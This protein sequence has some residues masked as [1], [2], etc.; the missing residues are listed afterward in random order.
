LLFGYFLP[1]LKF[2]IDGK[3]EFLVKYIVPLDASLLSCL[4]LAFPDSSITTLRSWVKHRRIFVN[5]KMAHQVGD[6]IVKGAT[7]E[8]SP[9]PLEKEGPLKIVYED[10]DLIVVDKPAGLL[11][12]ADEK[13]T[14]PSV[15]AWIKHRYP[16]KMIPV[17]HRLDKDT[18]GLI[19]FPLNSESF[20]KLKAMLAKREIK[21]VYRALLEGE[22]SGEGVWENFLLE[23]KRFVVRVCESSLK[24]S[25]FAKTRYVVLQTGEKYSLLDC[26]LDTGKKNQIRVQAAHHGHPVAGDEKYG[27]T[28]EDARRLCLHARLLEF[29]HPVTKKKMIFESNPPHFFEKL[30]R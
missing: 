19:L 6:V 23:D 26:F 30:C 28:L 29:T 2:K 9:K 4:K 27:A 7:I 13:N 1:G 15:H 5:G 11:S 25:V 17:L 10:A 22:M 12:V 20:R 8:L 21:R 24:E 3:K 16:G 18:S 14:Q